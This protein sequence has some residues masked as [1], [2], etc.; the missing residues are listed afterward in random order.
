MGKL[1]S[2][3]PW[4]VIEPPFFGWRSFQWWFLV[5][6]VH[7]WLQE[8]SQRGMSADKNEVEIFLISCSRRKKLA[9]TMGHNPLKFWKYCHINMV[10]KLVLGVKKLFCSSYLGS[11]SVQLFWFIFYFGR[12]RLSI[13]KTKIFSGRYDLGL[14]ITQKLSFSSK[15]K[16]VTQTMS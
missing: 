16:F 6:R 7:F 2:R 11:P 5:R 3:W 12:M 13:S 1:N 8:S 10:I 15:I 14:T 9:K 4:L